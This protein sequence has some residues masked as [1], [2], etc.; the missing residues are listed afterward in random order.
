M[1]HKPIAGAF[2]V[3]LVCLFALTGQM[4]QAQS[5]TPTVVIS[6]AYGGGGNI[7]ATYTHDFIELFNPN[8]E[9][10]SLAGWSVQYASATGTVWQRT[11]LTGTIPAGG[12]YLVQ[13]AQG[14]GGTTPLPAPDAVGTIAM[15]SSRGKVALLR[16]TDLLARGTACPEGPSLMD[17]VG[18]GNTDCFTGGAAAPLLNNK[19]AAQRLTNG[20]TNTGGNG[21]DFQTGE[22]EP[23]NS[24]SRAAECLPASVDRATPLPIQNRAALTVPVVSLRPAPSPTAISPT[25]I[26]LN[27]ISPTQTLDSSGIP[28]TSTLPVTAVVVPA[29]PYIRISQIYGGGG[30]AGATFTHDFVELY[31]PGSVAVDVG[32]WSLQ[33]ASATGKTW[34][35]TP[36]TGTIAAG[37]FYLIQQAQGTGGSVPLP[38]PDAIGETAMSASN[39]KIALVP[40]TEPLIGV[41]PQDETIVDLVGYGSAE[42]FEGSG[43]A[44]RPSNTLGLQRIDEGSRDSD[45]NRADFAT[46]PPLPRRSD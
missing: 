24:I 35:V 22:P 12:Y 44:P 3:T 43:P 25:A 5:D 14:S 2:L 20:C 42:C 18:F 10:V 17:L 33:Y 9:P 34:L 7:G 13:Q 40:S 46:F 45:D 15:S 30:N 8:T 38:A 39:G 41:C 29:G 31:N 11:E 27:A 1:R 16:T 4:A 32:G 36:L 23:R 19:S 37:R 21:D 6:Q 28:L 26:S